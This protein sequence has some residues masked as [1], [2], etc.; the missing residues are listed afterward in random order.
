M[1]THRRLIALTALAG[2][3]ALL[4]A[5][6][7]FAGSGKKTATTKISVTVNK[8][9]DFKFILS[10]KTAKVGKVTFTFSN[11]GQLP[12]DFKLCSSNKGGT[13]NACKGKVTPLVTPGQKATLTVTLS[14]AGKYEYLCTVAGHAASGM[15]GVLTVK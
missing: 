6:P 14:K 13:A 10:P 2:I 9:N 12:H 11:K 4:A 3:V 5:L 7:A 1:I 15:K 8:S